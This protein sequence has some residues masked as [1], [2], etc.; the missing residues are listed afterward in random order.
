MRGYS[1][2]GNLTN[3]NAVVVSGTGFKGVFA[4]AGAG[5]RETAVFS[6]KEE[7]ESALSTIRPK[8]FDA[9]SLNY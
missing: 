1:D 6:T 5:R 7:A 4:L 3:I 9:Q 8:G 2:A